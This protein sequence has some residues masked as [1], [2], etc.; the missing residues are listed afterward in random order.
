MWLIISQI[1]SKYKFP[2][3]GI[4]IVSSIIGW[5]VLHY[6]NMESELNK[7]KITISQLNADL[8][9]AKQTNV[10]LESTVKIQSDINQK[11]LTTMQQLQHNVDIALAKS[12]VVTM[13]IP[14]DAPAGTKPT[15]MTIDAAAIQQPEVTQ[16]YIN[17][18]TKD[19]LRCIEISTG[20][21][22]TQDEKNGTKQNSYCQSYI[23]VLRN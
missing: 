6:K 10:L 7:N 18:Q 4:V 16:T 13:P 8:S 9:V 5:G 19:Q 14:K 1:F 3:I 22:L 2:I 23:N 17:I 20:S 12:K 11:Y 21:K 15:Q